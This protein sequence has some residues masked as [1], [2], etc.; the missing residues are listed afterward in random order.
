M[1]MVY[2]VTNADYIIIAEDDVKSE[3]I[4]SPAQEA[5]DKKHAFFRKTFN[6]A[7]IYLDQHQE[8]Q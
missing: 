3:D 7:I 5:F 8:W 1:Q 6:G 2:V 4:A